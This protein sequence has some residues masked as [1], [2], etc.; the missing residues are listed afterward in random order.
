MRGARETGQ[1]SAMKLKKNRTPSRSGIAR[2]EV[3]VALDILT[4]IS[5][6]A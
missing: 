6:L 1:S 3:A 4:E 2:K 5:V